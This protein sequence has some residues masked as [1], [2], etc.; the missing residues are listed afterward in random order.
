MLA[1]RLAEHEE[2]LHPKND[3]FETGKSKDQFSPSESCRWRLQSLGRITLILIAPFPSR[4]AAR[5]PD[6]MG[7]WH[8]HTAT[9]AP[10]LS[11][12]VNG[13][14]CIVVAAEATLRVD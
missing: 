12:D 4:D 13:V 7:N 3:Q 10:T 9:L 14:S 5:I 2:I 1:S 6:A 8:F 11:L